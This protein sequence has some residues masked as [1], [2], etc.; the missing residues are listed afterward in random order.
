MRTS[1]VEKVETY[2]N[3]YIYT[4]IHSFNFQH[5]IVGTILQ[6]QL[7][8]IVEGLLVPHLLPDLYGCSPCMRSE[9]FLTIITLLVMLD[10]F[11]NERL[12]NSYLIANLLN[13]CIVEHFFLDR[14]T[15]FDPFRWG[16]SV[17]KN[18]VYNLYFRQSHNDIL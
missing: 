1:L 7:L 15:N 18:S 12:A 17:Y 16:I 8:Q 6:Q 5:L 13:V 4:I 14:E 11:T 3:F 9:L 2:P 10:E